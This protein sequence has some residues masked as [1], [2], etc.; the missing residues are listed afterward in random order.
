MHS[1]IQSLLIIEL[2]KYL[3]N[4]YLDYYYKI[5]SLYKKFNDINVEILVEFNKE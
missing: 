5:I 4:Y 2:K 3:E 1:I